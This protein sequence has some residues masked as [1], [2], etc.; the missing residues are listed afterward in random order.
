MNT[1]PDPSPS[2]PLPLLLTQ[3]D[4]CGIGP[5]I[6]VAAGSRGELAGVVVLGDVEVLRRAARCLR[7]A[8]DV[9]R[10]PMAVLEDLSDLAE[11]P[12]G[13]LAVLPMRTRQPAWLWMISS[14]TKAS[15]PMLLRTTPS[16]A[17]RWMP[18]KPSLAAV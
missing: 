12:P 3:G 14:L 18:F 2:N 8:E 16:S 7:S 9:P 13:A 11:V 1:L 6:I 4:V 15:L 5:E 17:I 10:L